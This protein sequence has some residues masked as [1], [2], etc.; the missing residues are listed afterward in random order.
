M[1]GQRRCA[2][3]REQRRGKIALLN[4]GKVKAEMTIQVLR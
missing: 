1:N 2:Q 3:C 4:I